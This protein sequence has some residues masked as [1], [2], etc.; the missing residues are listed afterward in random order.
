MDLP[1]HKKVLHP[2]CNKTFLG[3]STEI[4]MM[5]GPKT[6][7]SLNFHNLSYLDGTDILN[8]ERRQTCWFLLI[9]LILEIECWFSHCFTASLTYKRWQS[10][11]I[12]QKMCLV[13]SPYLRYCLILISCATKK[14]VS[15]QHGSNLSIHYSSQRCQ[16]LFIVRMHI[17]IDPQRVHAH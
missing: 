10:D 5:L 14:G 1:D 17:L 7:D 11:F 12:F 2:R 6:N 16:K 9:F 8:Q 4:L 3:S 15:L 13:I